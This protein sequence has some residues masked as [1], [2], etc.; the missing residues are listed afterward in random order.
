[1]TRIKFTTACQD[2]SDVL[3][4]DFGQP[5]AVTHGISASVPYPR[6]DGGTTI[7]DTQADVPSAR[8]NTVSG[9]A[10]AGCLVAFSLTLFVPGFGDI[11]K[12]CVRSNQ[13]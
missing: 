2:A 13:N 4:L 5:R 3:S 1:M 7:C 10:K 6:E 11:R 8:T 9:L 12:L